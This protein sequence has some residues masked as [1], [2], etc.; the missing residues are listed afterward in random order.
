VAIDVREYGLECAVLI[1][2]EGDIVL[3]AHYKDLEPCAMCTGKVPLCAV[4]RRVITDERHVQVYADDVL[5][6]E[7]DLD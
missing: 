6:A 2:A 3:H 5:F 7:Y 1:S 4:I